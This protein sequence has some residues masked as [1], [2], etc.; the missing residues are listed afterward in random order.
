[1]TDS[2]PDLEELRAIRRMVA[3]TRRSAERHWMS[4]AIWG[5]GALIASLLSHYLV[6][7]AREQLIGHVWFGF[8]IV[9]SALAVLYGMREK[10]QTRVVTVAARTLDVAWTAVLITMVLL[11]SSGA[12]APQHIPGAIAIVLASGLWI[13]GGVLEFKPL[14][15][16][17]GLWWFGGLLMMGNPRQAFA[18]EIVLLLLGYLLPAVLLRRAMAEDDALAAAD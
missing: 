11:M 4:L 7:T 15:W 13:M 2:I 12:V 16:A 14:Y 5:V 9:G 10:R 3:E 18:I 8:W 17:A 6:L 1:M